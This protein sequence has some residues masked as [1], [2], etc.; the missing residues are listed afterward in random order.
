MWVADYEGKTIERIDP[1]TNKVTRSW[2]LQ[3]SPISVMPYSDQAWVVEADNT[4]I[5]IDDSTKQNLGQPTASVGNQ[6]VAAI[7]R[8]TA[9]LL[10]AWDVIWVASS[11]PPTLTRIGGVIRNGCGVNL[12]TCSG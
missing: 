5:A 8:D 9:D 6:P 10:Q 4:M 11:G 3:A 2:S 12:P 7:L 1:G